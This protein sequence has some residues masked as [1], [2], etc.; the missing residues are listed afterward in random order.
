MYLH[1]YTIQFHPMLFKTKFANFVKSCFSDL[2]K[3]W[4]PSKLIRI[5]TAELNKLYAPLL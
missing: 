4:R 1:V 3:I 5:F 2:T